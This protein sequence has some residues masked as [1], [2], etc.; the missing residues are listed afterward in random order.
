[1]SGTSSARGAESDPLRNDAAKI[2]T[3]RRLEAKRAYEAPG[4]YHSKPFV[5]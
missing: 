3:G 5:T 1:M 2:E 4:A